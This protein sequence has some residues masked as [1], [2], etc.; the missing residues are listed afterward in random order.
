L[1]AKKIVKKPIKP[2]KKPIKKPA[3]K[4]V[5]SIPLIERPEVPVIEKEPK[6]V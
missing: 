5:E 4:K 2:I 6:I 3:P 1:P